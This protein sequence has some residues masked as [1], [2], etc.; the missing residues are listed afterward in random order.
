MNYLAHL[1]LSGDDEKIK[2]GNFIGDYVKGKQH[3][4]FEPAIQYGVLLHRQIDTF[5]DQHQKIKEATN[6]FRARYGRYS[7][8][9]IDIIFDHFLAKNW[10][11]YSDETLRNFSKHT[12]AT[13]LSHFSILP[14]RVKLFL[15][16]LIQHRR[17]ESYAHFEGLHES[18]EIMAR[19]TSLPNEADFALQ[20]LH[21]NY[22]S[23]QSIFSS[24][25]AELKDFAEKQIEM[26]I[27]KPVV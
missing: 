23:L 27:K 17:L 7:G 12:Y 22:S 4:N 13:L 18:M 3:E 8:I 16:F 11:D 21:S 15:P 14:N 1:Y 5:T 10:N 25:F 19:R 26:G 2:V 9:V 6:F 24:F 20:V